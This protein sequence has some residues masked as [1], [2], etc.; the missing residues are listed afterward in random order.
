MLL[1]KTKIGPSK[2]SGIGLFANQFIPKGTPTWKF[3]SG[4][5][6]K[7]DKSELANLSEPA[8]EQFLKYAYLNPKTNKYILCFDDARF[9][10]H[11]DNPNCIDT[12]FPDDTEGIDVAVRDIQEGEELTCNYKEFDADFDY[13]MSIH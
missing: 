10:N 12:E 13:K 2:I 8:K 6:L 5:D 4:F 7:I 3:Q 1:V 9:F 11:S